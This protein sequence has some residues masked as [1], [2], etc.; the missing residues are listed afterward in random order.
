MVSNT[1]AGMGGMVEMCG[2]VWTVCR[3]QVCSQ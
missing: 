2:I 3:N 1:D